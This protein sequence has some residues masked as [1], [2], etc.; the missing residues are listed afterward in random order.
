LIEIGPREQ[1]LHLRIGALDD[2]WLS[3]PPAKVATTHRIII[4]PAGDVSAD[5][6]DAFAELKAPARRWKTSVKAGAVIPPAKDAPWVYDDLPL[7]MPNPWKRNL[8]PAD[9][10]FF[11][12]GRAAVLTFDGDVWIV[13]RLRCCHVDPLCLRSARAAELVHRERCDPCF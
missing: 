7:P 4:T 3:V 2:D 5:Q 9:L 1:K 6:L 13:D 12:D 8:R 10:E 11:A